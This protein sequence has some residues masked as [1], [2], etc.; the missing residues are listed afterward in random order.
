MYNHRIESY[1]VICK[2]YVLCALE[3]KKLKIVFHNNRKFADKHFK[4]DSCLGE[5]EDADGGNIVID[6]ARH[7]KYLQFDSSTLN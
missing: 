2:Y 3:N 6:G 1:Y 5:C 4:I 7:V